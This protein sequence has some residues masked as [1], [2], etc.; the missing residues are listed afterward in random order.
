MKKPEKEK[1]EKQKIGQIGENAVC[2]YLERKGYSIVDRNYLRKWGELDI[3]A[4]K[5]NKL[6]FIEVKSVSRESALWNVSHETGYRPEDNMHPWKVER[7]KRIIQTYLADKN[8]LEN[9][10]WQFDVATVYIDQTKR[11]CKVNMLEDVILE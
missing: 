3:V 8:V 9:D 4:K 2:T 11:L 6:Y 7:L 5:S 1:T 10:E